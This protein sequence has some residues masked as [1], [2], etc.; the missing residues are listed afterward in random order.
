MYFSFPFYCEKTEELKLVSSNDGDPNENSTDMIKQF[1][2]TLNRLY[3]EIKNEEAEI[4]YKDNYLQ[5]L[6]FENDLSFYEWPS[7]DFP[8][9]IAQL[10]SG[11]KTILYSDV[12][13]TLFD[14]LKFCTIN[15]KIKIKSN[16]T[17]NGKLNE[18]LNKNVLVELTHSGI[19]NY[20]FKDD[21]YVIN[22]LFKSNH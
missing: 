4:T 14:A 2:N 15:I 21:F 11:N 9:E 16:H 17:A 6:E 13:S 20:K 8:L 7:N 1:S 3:N 12:K 18:L 5:Y 10:L 19:S 22:L